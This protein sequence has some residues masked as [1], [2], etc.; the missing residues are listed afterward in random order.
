[1][2][3]DVTLDRKGMGLVHVDESESNDDG[4]GNEDKSVQM[5]RR[6][7]KKNPATSQRFSEL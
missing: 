1:M 2:S 4:E 7:R 6:Y 3:P 5:S